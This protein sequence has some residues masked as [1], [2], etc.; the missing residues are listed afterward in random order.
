MVIFQGVGGVLY[1]VAPR[2][3]FSRVCRLFPPGRPR[4][5]SWRAELIALQVIFAPGYIFPLCTL[6]QSPVAAR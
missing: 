2:F 3:S 6:G 4:T 5:P 1:R